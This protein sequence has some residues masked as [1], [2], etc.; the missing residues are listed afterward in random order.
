M[1]A[2]GYES[3]IALAS[4]RLSGTT[5]GKHDSSSPRHEMPE[6]CIIV[7]PPP[8]EGAGNAGA[9]IAPA[10]LRAN[11]KSTQASHHRYAETTG[12]PCAMV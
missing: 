3:R 5:V 2:C 4:A 1:K 7:A 12:I 11:E 10:A 9:S 8:I 6:L